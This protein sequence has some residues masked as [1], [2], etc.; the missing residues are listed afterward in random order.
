MRARCLLR[1]LP[2]AVRHLLACG[3]RRGG[4]GDRRQRRRKIDPAQMHRRR[5]RIASRRHPVRRR[6][7]RGRARAR[8]GRARHRARAG[9]AAALPLALG[10]GEP[11]DRRTARPAGAMAALPHLR[12]VPG[13]GRAASSAQ[14]F[15]LR[16]RA[17]DG[18]HRAGTDV[19]PEASTLRRDQPRSC[20]RCRARGLCA[21]AGDRERRKFTCHRRARHRAGA[22]GGKPRLLPAG[23]SRRARRCRRDA[24]AR[25]N[26]G[27]LLRGV[28]VAFSV[29]PSRFAM[30]EPHR[31]LPPPAGEGQ[32]GGIQQDPCNVA[33]AMEWVNIFIQ[34][35]LIGG[36]YAMFAAGLALIF[37]VMRLVNI[38]HGDLIVLAAYLA[39]VVTEA[40]GM[41]P[42]A[43]LVLV[44]PLMALV[45][46][47]LQRGILNRTL[48]PDLWPPLLVTF[49]L[50]VI[51][52]NGLLE[53]FTADSRRLQAGSIEI[54]SVQLGGGLA[55]G[56][57]PL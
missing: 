2:G 27:G 20:A 10:R 7:D 41:N 31:S 54:A 52:Q 26:L 24:D 4:G 22:Y 1:R 16:R 37:G 36:L 6:A 5:H 33:T 46:Y 25:G 30:A 48:G 51:I 13:T 29:E 40:L 14:H 53:L 21:S 55:I 8:G 11:P 19:Q 9:R 47:L 42:L 34:G 43:S 45:G 56:I 57:L 38:A 49:G 15:A 44:V 39:L 28:M 50:S 3:G 18:R 35:V 32:G 23:G 17:A 12:A